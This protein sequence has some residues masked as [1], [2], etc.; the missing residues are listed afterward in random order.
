M[1]A[2]AGVDIA[3]WDLAGHIVGEPVS[4]LLGGCYRDRIPVYA[5]GVAGLRDLDEDTSRLRDASRAFADQGYRGVKLGIGQGVEADLCSIAVATE[6]ISG[7][8]DLIADVAARYDVAQARDLL[9]RLEPGALH[10][11]EA[12]LPAEHR[13]GYVAL[14]RESPVPITTD[15]LVNRWQCLDYL[16]ASAVHAVLPDACR[17]GGFTECRRIAILADAFGVR[18]IPH[19]SLGSVINIAASAHLAATLPYVTMMEFWAGDSPLTDSG[20]GTQLRPHS[21][22]L[23]VPT[24]P[25]LG[26][27]LDEDALLAYAVDS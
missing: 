10:W 11:L 24:G 3:L 20:I 25:G 2:I 22:Y 1:E 16:R 19:M 12:P 14:A 15:L 18:C 4:C 21:G 27:D 9:A 17:A 26:I 13:D 5:S 7:H 23:R 8:C 6:A